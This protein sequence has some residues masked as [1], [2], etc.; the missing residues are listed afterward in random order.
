MV[1][2]AV[3]FDVDGVLLELTSAEENAFFAPFE[4][5]YG[6]RDL[7]R[8]WNS[9]AIRNDENIIAEILARHGLPAREHAEV[10]VDY[11]D[12]L[13]QRM[14]NGVIETIAIPGARDLLNKLHGN[15]QLGIATANFLG[16]AKLRLQSVDFWNPVSAHAFGAEGGGHKHEILGRAISSTGFPKNR[17]VYVGDNLNDVEAGLSNGVQ[18]VGFSANPGRLNE[19][20]RAGTNHISNNHLDTFR[21]IRH[22][23]QG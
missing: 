22:L 15:L 17:V 1:D 13:K 6:L 20:E 11:L 23:L 21:L 12:V 4:Q 5:R 16:A 3:I 19:L 2:A 9:Y 10:V 18:F 8:D 7:S 14:R